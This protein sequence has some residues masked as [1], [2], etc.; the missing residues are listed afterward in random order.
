MLI[1][2]RRLATIVGRSGNDRVAIRRRS[3]TFRL[4][5]L[6]QSDE[7]RT[8]TSRLHLDED[9]ALP[10]FHMASG[11][12]SNHRRFHPSNEDLTLSEA[13]MRCPVIS[14]IAIDRNRP[15]SIVHLMKIRRSGSVHVLQVMCRNPDGYPSSDGD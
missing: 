15:M 3:W 6:Q 10:S 11:K 12:P 5:L 2:R 1:L 4:I 9:P 8:T 7:D 14:E 13:S